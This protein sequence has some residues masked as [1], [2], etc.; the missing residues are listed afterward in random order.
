MDNEVTQT[1]LNLFIQSILSRGEKSRNISDAYERIVTR[2]III[3][4]TEL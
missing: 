4:A 3:L 2:G 1:I